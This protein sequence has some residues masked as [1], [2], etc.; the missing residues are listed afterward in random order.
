MGEGLRLLALLV[1]LVIIV[2]GIVGLVAPDRL[3][4]AAQY[5]LTPVGVYA[6][7]ALRIGMGFVLV[8]VAPISPAED[9]ASA[10]SHCAR[11]RARDATLRR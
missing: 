5:V 3:T 7:A 4:T 6:I 11:G 9:L 2:I 10:W 8:L 1:A